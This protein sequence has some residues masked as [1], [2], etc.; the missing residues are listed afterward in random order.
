MAAINARSRKKAER[1]N[2]ALPN[3]RS[4][5]LALLK[6]ETAVLETPRSAGEGF[7]EVAHLGA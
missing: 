3:P 6:L 1:P 2:E 7:D 4:G 5:G